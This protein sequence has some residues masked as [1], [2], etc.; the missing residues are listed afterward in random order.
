[1]CIVPNI[2]G[3]TILNRFSSSIYNVADDIHGRLMARYP[4]APEWWYY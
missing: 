2:T 4:D 3:K 1:M